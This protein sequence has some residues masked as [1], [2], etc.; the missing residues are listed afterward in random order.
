MTIWQIIKLIRSNNGG[1]YIS[2]ELNNF[3]LI[4]SVIHQLISPYSPKSNRIT[5]SCNQIINTIVHSMTIAIL[6]FPTL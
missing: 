4:N 2:N 5:E 3:F 1:E 6:D